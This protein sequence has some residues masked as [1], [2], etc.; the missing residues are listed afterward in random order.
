MNK[1]PEI[2]IVPQKRT[3]GFPRGKSLFHILVEDGLNVSSYC[4]GQGICGK[5]KVRLLSKAFPPSE[6]DINYLSDDELKDGIRLACGVY[7]EGGEE[8]EIFL[9]ASVPSFK[10]EMKKLPFSVDPWQEHPSV[11]LVMGI[12]LGTTNIVG[13]LLDPVTGETISSVAIANGQSVFGADIMTRLTYSS[14][15]GEGASKKMSDITL[16]DIEKLAELTTDNSQKITDVVAVMNAA[17]ETLMLGL[18]PDRIGRYPYDSGICEPVHIK[19][20]IGGPLDGATIHVPPVVGGFVGSDIVSA[21]LVIS[22]LKQEPP[23]MLV[24]IGTNA[25]V[26][27][28]TEET[29]IACSTAAGSAFEGVGISC[30]MRGIEGAIENV[31]LSNGQLD[32]SVIGSKSAGG[33]TGSGLFS[34]I[35]EL[36]RGEAIDSFG[37]IV[38]ERLRPEMVRQ[39]TSGREV[40]LSYH[41][42]VSEEDIQ[43]F[44]LAKA[45]TR[46]AVD[47]LL[48]LIYLDPNELTAI[49]LSGT[50][51]G[52]LN[53]QDIIAI[54]LFPDIELQKIHYVGNAAATGAV[55]MA[56]SKSAF[57]EA[58][59]LAKNI[60]HIELSGNKSF[61]EIFQSQVH[62]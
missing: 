9:Q 41:V 24:D 23:Y 31:R 38:P 13:H 47:T 28:V 60:K 44:I 55:A 53:L 17:I 36:I 14:H 7:P 4:G 43:K 62:L 20:F 25:E 33:I 1:T 56:L 2:T 42:F 15:H 30:G 11:G 19:P 37:V 45:A 46:S 18:N 6:L 61:I 26:V 5:C 35:G 32:I 34:L 16:A 50:F 58:C 49:F 40:I 51:G 29:M 57:Q 52:R 22:K 27:V 10:L 39:G 12:D 21:L 54:G 3:L 59:L 8:V 48:S